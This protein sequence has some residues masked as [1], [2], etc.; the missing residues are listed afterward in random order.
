MCCA[1]T[2]PHPFSNVGVLAITQ[3]LISKHQ[4]SA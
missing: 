4:N 3:H 1:T 2:T